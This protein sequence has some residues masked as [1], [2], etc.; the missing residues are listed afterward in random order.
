MDSDGPVVIAL[1]GSPHSA[2]TLRWGVTEATLRAAPV[3]LAR[4]YREPRELV[5]WRWRPP[6][7]EDLGLDT[8]ATQYL[9]DLLEHVTVRNPYLSIGTRVLAGPEVPELRRLS[10]RAQLLVCGARGHAGRTRI[11][12]VSGRLAAHARCPVAVVR[13][14]HPGSRLD[15]ARVVVGVDGSPSSLAAARSAADEAAMRAVPLA[16]VHA[17]PRTAGPGGRGMPPLPPLAD[18]SGDEND[19]AH[20]AARE[21]TAALRA[22]HATLDVHLQLVDDDPV[23]ALVDASSE[24]QLLVVG[25]RGLGAVCGLLLGSVSNEVVRAAATTVLIWHDGENG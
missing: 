19:P 4:V 21:L 6:L 25:S 2:Q 14:P 8:E 17:R 9:A 12:A 5:A 13:E 11:G 3:L 20:A 15:G 24:A 18:R 16:V 10:E 7:G 23:Q 22:E 1:D